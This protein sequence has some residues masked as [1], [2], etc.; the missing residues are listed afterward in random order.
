MDN[1]LNALRDAR[2]EILLRRQVDK[3]PYPEKIF[4]DDLDGRIAEAIGHYKADD[5]G[6]QQAKVTE[7][8]EPVKREEGDSD[9][10]SV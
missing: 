8:I 5:W 10:E 7:Q 9:G 6:K 4:L 1:I 3:L 2:I